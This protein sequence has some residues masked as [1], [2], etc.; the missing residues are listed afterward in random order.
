MLS[1]N[2][3]LKELYSL[4][5]KLRIYRAGYTMSVQP[6][7]YGTLYFKKNAACLSCPS[8]IVHKW[9][10]IDYGKQLLQ[11]ELSKYEKTS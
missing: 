4:L 9:S 11:Q 5:I 10:T 1:D 3:K 7:G 2:H 6:N 8:D